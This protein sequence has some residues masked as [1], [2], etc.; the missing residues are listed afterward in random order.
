MSAKRFRTRLTTQPTRISQ[1]QRVLLPARQYIVLM[2]PA[3]SSQG[4]H[5]DEAISAA[6]RFVAEGAV[7]TAFQRAGP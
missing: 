5:A 4:R 1:R 2:A 6:Q 7:I 3:D